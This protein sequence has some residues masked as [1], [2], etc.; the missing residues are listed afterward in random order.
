M[1]ENHT[2]LHGRREPLPAAPSSIGLVNT[3]EL[4]NAGATLTQPYSAADGQRI[5]TVLLPAIPVS[6]P[7]YA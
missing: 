5:M 3:A 1:V 7:D 4:R 6:T 2:I